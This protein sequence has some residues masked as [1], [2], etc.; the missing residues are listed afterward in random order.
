MASEPIRLRDPEETHFGTRER[1]YRDGIELEKGVV[2]TEDWLLRNEEL[3][4]DYWK[5]LRRIQIY[6]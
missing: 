4:Y 5:W 6:I 3:L 1:L 2:I